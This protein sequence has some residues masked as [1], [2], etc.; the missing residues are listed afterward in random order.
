MSMVTSMQPMM[1]SIYIQQLDEMKLSDYAKQL[2][3]SYRTAW[4][5][6]KSGKISGYQMATG[7]IIVTENEHS[8]RSQNVA[9]YAR[10]DTSDQSAE[11]DA[12]VERLA[13]YCLAK[14]Y[15]VQKIVREIG[16]SDCDDRPR[17]LKLLASPEMTVIVVETRRCLA[18]NGLRYIDALLEAQERRVEAVLPDTDDQIPMT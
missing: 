7:T 8:M 3:V 12:Q 2:G 15:Q 16:F 10:V 6:Y 17:L 13:H 11:L 18:E 4:R 9:I 5:W 1:L 14:G